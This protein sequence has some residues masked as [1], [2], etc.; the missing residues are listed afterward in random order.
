MIGNAVAP[1]LAKTFG[2]S[3]MQQLRQSISTAA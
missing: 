2:A 3:L 1:P